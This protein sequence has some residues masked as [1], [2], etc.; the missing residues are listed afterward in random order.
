MILCFSFVPPVSFPRF[1]FLFVVSPV[2]ASPRLLF[3]CPC[4]LVRVSASLTRTAGLLP[5]CARRTNKQSNAETEFEM[6]V[7]VTPSE[8]LGFSQATIRETLMLRGQAAAGHL[9]AK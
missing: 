1:L 2:L 8:F 6:S 3:A 9:Q 4:L 5:R 7:S